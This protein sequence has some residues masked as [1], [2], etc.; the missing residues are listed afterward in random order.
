MQ[1]LR[2]GGIYVLPDA[3]RVVIYS[4]QSAGYVCYPLADWESLCLEE[5]AEKARQGA[6]PLYAIDCSGHIFRIEQ[7]TEWTVDNLVDTGA[8]ACEL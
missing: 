1:Q 8:T 6:S 3:T 4:N 7:C 5:L 2:Y